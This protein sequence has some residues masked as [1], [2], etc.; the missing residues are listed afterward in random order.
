[1]ETELATEPHWSSAGRVTGW[2]AVGCT[3]AALMVGLT[4]APPDAVQGD[5]A[6][7]LY[8]HVPAAWTAYL[9]F[10]AVLIASVQYL[11]T[12][13]YRWD[14]YAGVAAEIG[15]A[16]TA[17]TIA[18]GS[19]WGRAVWGLWW[20]WDPRLVTTALLLLIY[21]GYLTLRRVGE[22]AVPRARRAAWLGI[23][24]SLMMPVVH[25]SVVWWRSLHQPATLLAPS[26]SP[27]I[28]SVMAT[29]LALSVC[30]FTTACAWL[31]LRRNAALIA[32]Q[33][34]RVDMSTVDQP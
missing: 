1:M 7:L 34:S 31:F 6:R 24:G 11:R 30:A 18:V 27:P 32:A 2:V 13:K 8:L 17:L 10:A 33:Q 25:F 9:A 12:G 19:V 15:V 20:T 28:D 3:V 26:V 16:M 5:A 4:I 23:G 22:S 29:A 14:R 21:A